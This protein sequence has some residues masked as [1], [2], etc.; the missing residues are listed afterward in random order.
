MDRE[1]FNEA[2]KRLGSNEVTITS[3]PN[4]AAINNL[5]QDIGQWAREK[6]FREDFD[7]AD[8]LEAFAA[9][10]FPTDDGR[11]DNLERIAKN[12]RRLANVSKLMLMVSEISE[13]LEGMRDGGNYGE[14]LG[15]LIIR[16]LENAE[17]NRIPIGD[18]VTAKVAKN[19]DRP[20]RH[21]KK[22]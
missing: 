7:D 8:W 3:D 9:E 14:E 2:T 16:V 19:R 17:C 22:F 13:G 5:A 15:D 4:A 10:Y 21:G 11:R 20:Y 12:H 6:G 18:E 1:E